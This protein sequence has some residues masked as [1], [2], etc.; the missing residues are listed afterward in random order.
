MQQN[1]T[2]HFLVLSHWDAQ[3]SQQLRVQPNCK[4]VLRVTAKKVGSG[5]GYV[6]IRD[7]AH[8]R[9]TLTFNVC[10][11]DGNGTYVNDNTPITKE[12]AFY[13]HTEHMWV[14]ISETDGAFHIESIE[15]IETQE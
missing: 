9:E 14:E 13:P 10:D 6:T 3:V 1:G 8:H 2:T 12:V 11:Y 7:G 15:F 5:D 4:Y